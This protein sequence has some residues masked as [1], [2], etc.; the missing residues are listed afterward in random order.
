MT[1]YIV[2][3]WLN[4][5]MPKLVLQYS[6]M[7]NKVL[8]VILN[9]N[10]WRDVVECMQSVLKSDYKNYEFYLVENSDKNK[11]DEVA[12]MKKHAATLPHVAKLDIQEHNT[13]FAGG[14]NL[15]ISYAL[16]HD[17]DAVA[18]LNS[19]A[20]V[21]KTWL[22]NLVT[23]MNKTDAG[24]VTGLMLD[25][26]GEKIVNS[27]DIYTKWG[28]PEQRDE[29][30]LPAQAAKSGYVF[31]A[32][33]GA[34]LYKTELFRKVGLF[35]EKIFAYNEDIDMSWRAQLA[36]FKVYY[37]KSA[38]VYHEGGTSTN[39][40]FKTRQVF[41]N[42]PIVMWKNVPRE[43]LWS[44]AWRFFLAYMM[45]FGFKI[46]RGEGWPALKGIG[47]SWR[48]LPHALHERRKIMRRFRAEFKN[49]SERRQ[50]LKEINNLV[51]PQLPFRQI[52]R[53]KKFLGRK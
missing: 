25:E 50:R 11:K 38:V 23:A 13:G 14:V 1:G 4:S 45:F 24:A 41:A 2:I 22:K 3:Q 39:S 7:T 21:E 26:K 53:L 33:G 5:L 36:G 15:G 28:V 16:E 43:M 32:T 35:D 47:R 29:G 42:L 51:K 10:H 19:D 12:Q 44:V 27:G 52:Q 30:R 34:T 8:I 48:F 9:L 46:T 40:A 37:E 31:G 20:T 6:M 18:L 17:F 49:K